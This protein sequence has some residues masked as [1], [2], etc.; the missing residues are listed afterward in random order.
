MCFFHLPLHTALDGAIDAQLLNLDIEHLSNTG[1]TLNRV[2]DL[3]QIL[4][5]RDREL[6]VG[7]DRVGQFARIVHPHGGDHGFVI[8]V[9]ALL[10]VLLEKRG[11]PTD[12]SF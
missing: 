3:Q 6:Q 5:F 2:E 1:E 10:D 9:L 8:Q 12:Q 11:D 7:A 4:F